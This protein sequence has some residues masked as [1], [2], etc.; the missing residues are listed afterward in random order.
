[1]PC[2]LRISKPRLICS[3][4]MDAANSNCEEGIAV[5]KLCYVLQWDDGK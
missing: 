3:E 5:D 1:M 2:M 4:F